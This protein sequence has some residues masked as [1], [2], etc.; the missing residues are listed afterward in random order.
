MTDTNRSSEGEVLVVEDTQASLKL[1]SDLLRAAGYQV[2]E[3]PNGELALW[4]AN[5]RPPELIL[6]DVRMPGIDGLEVCRR[7]KQNPSLCEV[8]VLFL[9]AQH[10]AEDK[11]AGFKAGA[12][13]FIAKPYQAEEVLA[14]TRTHLQ[15]ARTRKALQSRN[16]ELG[17]AL[18]ALNEAREE[19]RRTESMA[20]LGSMVAGIAHEMNTPIGNSLL[21]ASALAGQA[22]DMARDVARLMSEQQ[23]PASTPIPKAFVDFIADTQDGCSLVLRNLERSAQL[24]A[25]FKKLAASPLNLRRKNFELDH[26][27]VELLDAK[28]SQLEKHHVSLRLNLQPG[29]HMDSYPEALGEVITELLGNAIFHAFG[30]AGGQIEIS[31]LTSDEIDPLSPLSILVRDNGAGIASEHLDRVFVPFFTTKIGQG[32]NGLGLNI[33]QNLLRNVLG[34]GIRVEASMGQGS[35]FAMQIP[36]QAPPVG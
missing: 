33:V 9:S 22:R 19:A 6:L 27:L 35:C 15:L 29:L 31:A 30:S 20:A 8:P 23:P 1:L 26:Y 13:D 7:L 2:R 3:A 17:T 25:T 16:Q 11:L 10:D 34:G 36:R 32:R 28:Q 21:V 24:I 12:V 5:A 18:Q 4:S 14:R